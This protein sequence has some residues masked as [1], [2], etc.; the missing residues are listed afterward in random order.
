[1]LEPS[2][3][4]QTA[5]LTE[6][7]GTHGTATADNAKV[8]ALTLANME[9]DILG[10]LPEE[11]ERVELYLHQN[12][13]GETE[14][15]EC[16]FVPY[17]ASADGVTHFNQFIYENTS[18]R[19]FFV[20][21][22]ILSVKIISQIVFFIAIALFTH[23]TENFLADVVFPLI[24]LMILSFWFNEL[25]K[26]TNYIFQTHPHD[27]WLFTLNEQGIVFYQR[28]LVHGRFRGYRAHWRNWADIKTISLKKSIFLRQP[29]WQIECHNPILGTHQIRLDTL[30]K[31]EREIAQKM[32]TQYFQA[33]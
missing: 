2:I 15:V 23:L 3:I 25:M 17:H 10:W 5:T 19:K 32:M 12:E 27:D 26:L 30:R 21:K 31:T 1:M 22:T 33:A 4:R 13:R 9:R 29:Y 11:G 28:V 24:I 7:H 14:F 18:G 6:W 16:C 20:D 8:Y